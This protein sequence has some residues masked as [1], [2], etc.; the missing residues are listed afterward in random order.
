MAAM[1][2]FGKKTDFGKSVFDIVPFPPCAPSQRAARDR[3]DRGF[4]QMDIAMAGWNGSAAARTGAAVPS[5]CSVA[6]L[7]T[8]WHGIAANTDGSALS[9]FPLTPTTGREKL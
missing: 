6:P 4:A 3:E 8:S 7:P 9:L 1:T 2:D 5:P